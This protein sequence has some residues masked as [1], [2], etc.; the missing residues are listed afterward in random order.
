M[1]QPV[2]PLGEDQ[3]RLLLTG[4]LPEAEVERLAGE[5]SD[6]ARVA[7]IAE[8]IVNFDDVLL[9]RLRNRTPYADPAV[10]RLVERVLSKFRSSQKLEPPASTATDTPVASFH[11]DQA[12]KGSSFNPFVPPVSEFPSQLEHFRLIRKIGEGGMGAVYVALDTRL[13]RQVALKTLLPMIAGDAD[14]KERFLREARAVAALE[15]QHILAIYHVGEYQGMSYLAMPLLKGQG[16]SEI[17]K[18]RKPLSLEESLRYARQ[19]AEGL[20]AA[21][22]KGVTHRDVKPSN[23]WIEPT[24]GRLIA[25]ERP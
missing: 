24:D 1:F 2:N 10:E 4:Q 25:P 22:A 19:I 18:Q 7:A 17:L 20:A 13:D 21:H 9:D 11:P 8:T 14:A 5:L 23:V 16:L 3:L 12:E 6:D 15:H